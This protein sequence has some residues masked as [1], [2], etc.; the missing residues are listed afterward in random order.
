MDI[1][2]FNLNQKELTIENKPISEIYNHLGDSPFFIYS[3]KVLIEKINYLRQH[4]PNEVKLHYAIKA[5]PNSE[6]IQFLSSYVDGFDVSSVNELKKCLL[7]NIKRNDISFAGPGKNDQELEYAIA[8]GIL[9]NVESFN[10]LKRIELIQVKINK[11]ARIALR[12][13]PDFDMKTSGMKMSGGSKVF[14]I[15]SEQIPEILDYIYLKELNFEGFQI[16]TGSQNLNA[17]I[18]CEA[19]E[20][21]AL[22]LISLKPHI[23]KP[24]RSINL[25]GGFGIPYFNDDKELDLIPIKENLS[26]I[27]KRLITEFGKIEIIIELGRYLVGE[28]GIYVAKIIDKKISRGQTF[29]VLNGGMN[30]HLAA[31]GN[32]GQVIKKNYPIYNLTHLDS[33]SP[34]IV[35]ITGPLCTPLDQLAY[36][37]SIDHCRI[38]DLIGVFQSGAYGYSASPINFLSHPHPKEILV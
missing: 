36:Q 14:G 25:G 33:N 26:E 9:L 6:V 8:N 23:K 11:M 17:K 38:G 37:I 27:S 10:E 30:H 1:K 34:E 12:I 7:T 21:S 32:L 5:N 29:I 16:Y 3:K 31:S 18:L 28:S 13:N 35:N 24:I 22:L 20:K 19:Q 2:Y 15:D 4:L